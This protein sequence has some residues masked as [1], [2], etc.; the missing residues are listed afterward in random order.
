MQL[1]PV[2]K[3]GVFFG[4][5]DAKQLA[6]NPSLQIAASS[7]VSDASVDSV[8]VVENDVVDIPIVKTRRVKK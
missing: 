6:N 3:N 5:A 1:F 2:T 4:Y 8:A 7:Q